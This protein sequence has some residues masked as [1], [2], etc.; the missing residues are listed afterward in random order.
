MRKADID[1]KLHTPCVAVA[2]Y[3]LLSVS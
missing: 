1:S 2:I 3:N